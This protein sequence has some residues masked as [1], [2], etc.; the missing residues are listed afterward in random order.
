MPRMYFQP[1]SGR[2]R[3]TKLCGLLNK[4]SLCQEKRYKKEIFLHITWAKRHFGYSWTYKTSTARWPSNCSQPGQ[5]PS[6]LLLC[7]GEVLTSPPP[8]TTRPAALSPSLGRAAR[9]SPHLR[10]LLSPCIRW[11]LPRSPLD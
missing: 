4:V 11:L 1:S 7:S 6:A 10:W 8:A 3:T 5:P 2:L 9:R